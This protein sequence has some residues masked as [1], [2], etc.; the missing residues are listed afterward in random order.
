MPKLNEDLSEQR[1]RELWQIY[2][3]VRQAH[4]RALKDEVVER[5]N[6]YPAPR[7]YVLPSTAINWVYNFEKI[8]SGRLMRIT[9]QSAD[10]YEVFRK[11]WLEH[12]DWDTRRLATEAVK[13]PAPSYYASKDIFYRRKSR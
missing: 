3:E 1:K 8:G 9:Q 10:F 7:F 13:Q 12:P 6:R 5:I 2:A 4:P 11:L